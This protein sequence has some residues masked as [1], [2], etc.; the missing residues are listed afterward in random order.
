MK[1]CQRGS[2]AIE[3]PLKFGLWTAIKFRLKSHFAENWSSL[4]KDVGPSAAVGIRI[5]RDYI[6]NLQ[7]TEILYIH[8]GF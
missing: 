8:I 2:Q 3:E 1:H 7:E 5:E 6:S 4:K